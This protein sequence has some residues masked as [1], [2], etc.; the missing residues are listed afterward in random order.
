LRFSVFCVILFLDAYLACEVVTRV[1]RTQW[2]NRMNSFF[3]DIDLRDH[4]HIISQAEHNIA[5]FRSLASVL[6]YSFLGLIYLYLIT[7]ET[8]GGAVR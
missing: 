1:W 7:G 5:W 3:Q 8:I 4:H 6:Y 2:R